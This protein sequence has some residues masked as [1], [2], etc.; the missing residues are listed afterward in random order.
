MKKLWT[1]RNILL[2]VVL[3]LFFIALSSKNVLAAPNVDINVNG[4]DAPSDYVDNIKL[5]IFLTIVAL[6]PSIIIMVTSFTRIVIVLSFLKN[7]LG[8]QQSI[9]SQVLIG[10][11]IFLTIFIMRPV[12]NDINDKAL[13][14]YSDGKITSQEAI[15]IGIKPLKDFMLK[16]T[17]E[18]DLE[19]FIELTQTD[20][21][22]LSKE[23]VPLTSLIPAFVI[24]ELKTA[25][26]M[27]FL[28][29]LPFI[30]IDI[31]VGSVLMS[32]GMF[33]LPPVMVALPFKLLLF[34]MVDGWHLIIKSLVIS[35]K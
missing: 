27:G 11:A 15:E 26:Q 28:I 9:P 14:P 13:V 17:R 24:S 18:K 35:F 3:S 4:G 32:M 33:M 19:L 29:F 25:F 21:E 7:A 20:T 30:I 1:K 22:T 2:M 12:Y 16:E 23:N 34:V 8:A 10:L 5:L 6:L 31:V